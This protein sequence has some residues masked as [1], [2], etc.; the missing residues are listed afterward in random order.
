MAPSYGSIHR[1][2]LRT[3][4]SL[5]VISVQEAKKA[6]KNIVHENEEVSIP[7][8]VNQINKEIKNIKQVLKI[9][10]DETSGEDVIV[11][12]SLGFDEAT[13]S[14]NLFPAS[15]LEYFRVLI[16]Q[17]MST[18]NRQITGIYALNLVGNMKSA[19]TKTAAQKILDTW[20]RMR[21]LEKEDRN[22]VLGVRTIQEFD[23]YLREN[24]PDAIDECCLCKQ[25]VFRGYNCISCGKAVHTRCLNKYTERMQKWPCCKIDYSP[26]QLERMLSQSSRLSQSQLVPAPQDETDDTGMSYENSDELTQEIPSQ[27]IIPEIS[28]RVSRKRKRINS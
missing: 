16:E 4:A 11:F 18:E 10:H 12:I 22:Y 19:Y 5:G 14:Q 26:D 17:I 8:L 15:E 24:M 23:G 3:V 21:Y 20:C 2:L 28:Q 7:E 6:L 9:T 1:Y 13:K 25:I 27:D